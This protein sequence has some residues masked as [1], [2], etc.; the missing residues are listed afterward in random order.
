MSENEKKQEKEEK[1]DPSQ[2]LIEGCIDD[3]AKEVISQMLERRL[4][5]L[6]PQGIQAKFVLR[7]Q[8]DLQSMPSC[9]E[10]LTKDEQKTE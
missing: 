1:F 8:N 3:Q 2:I 9:K 4:A 7:L 10:L 5:E 6:D